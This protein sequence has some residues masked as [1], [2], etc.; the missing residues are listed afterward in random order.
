MNVFTE[1]EKASM[2]S[3]LLLKNMRNTPVG[4]V[5]MVAATVLLAELAIMLFFATPFV[6]SM[7]P[8]DI[9]AVL[10]PLM[11]VV[12]IAPVLHF[13]VFRPMLQ[14]QADLRQ[15][16]EDLAIAAIAFEVQEGIIVTDEKS[17]ILRVNHSFVQI[18]G[19]SADEA[20]GRKPSLV[21]SGRQSKDFYRVM[22]DTLK[23]KQYWEGEIWNKRKNG[24]E[25]PQWLTITA[26]V[27]QDGTV[28]H[29]VGV[30]SDISIQKKNEAE[31]RQLA[32]YDFLTEL[33]NRHLLAD[34]MQ[35]VFA[36]SE[37]YRNHNAV[38]F[39]DLDHFK[40]LNDVHGHDIGDLMLIEVSLRLQSCVRANDTVA[41]LGGDEFVVM[42]VNLDKD[43]DRAAAH[44][45]QAAEKILH[46]LSLPIILNG[47]EFA[48]STSIG[49]SLFNHEATVNAVLKR[50]DSAMYQAKAAGRNMM[51]F[52][53]PAMQT[54]LEE[55]A[56]VGA[57]LKKA[58]V[59]QQFQLYYQA[60]V[61][62]SLRILGAEV[63]LR[64]LHPERGMIPPDQFIPLAEESR[65]I[66]TIGNWVLETACTQ[67]KKWESEASTCDLRLSIN[68]SACQF[69]QPDF[70]AQVRKVLDRNCI[71]PKKLTLEL[72]ESIAIDNI[73][74]AASKIRE[75]KK[76]GVGF[77]M[78]DFGTGHS[79]LAYLKHLPIDELKIDQRFVQNAI[80]DNV[81]A[82]LV[83]MIIAI[84]HCMKLNV[85]SEGVETEEQ[86]AFLKASGCNA[87]Q[88]YLFSK[89]VQLEEFEQ[90]FTSRLV[91][92]D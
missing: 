54:L 35:Q 34:R 30:F 44:A 42:L 13:F 83:R 91:V 86:M 36:I 43:T 47:Q 59:R 57:E 67:L 61:D 9:L 71:D 92:A 73:E 10:D 74:S 33:P 18:T 4:V 68:V 15:K 17:I 60:Q 29:Y 37:R 58:L 7:V 69:Y 62:S 46:M 76:I 45:K 65:L 6:I 63:L 32:F 3:L 84:A 52:F 70:V 77:S 25:Y 1:G 27:G 88:G 5:S 64:W 72:T 87:Y 79:S 24:E 66:L 53:D 40:T 23:S 48:C 90:L 49:I 82:A 51:C 26:V 75:L 78:D 28:T 55:Q 80:T 38:L 31:I 56:F 81:D 39:L 2:N 21:S 16:S 8:Q 22:W 50:A 41:R 85:V 20:V 89:P 11:L 14:S 19:Y 12:I